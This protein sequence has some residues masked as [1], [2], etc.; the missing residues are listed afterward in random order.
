MR[1][2]QKDLSVENRVELRGDLSI[3]RTGVFFG[4]RVGVAKRKSSHVFGSFFGTGTSKLIEVGTGYA[5]YCQ[6][7]SP[8]LEGC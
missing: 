5:R 6:K 7:L 2:P 8:G 4:G 3:Q 1:W